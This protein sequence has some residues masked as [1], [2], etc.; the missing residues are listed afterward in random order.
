M[1]TTFNKLHYLKEVMRL[2]LLNKKEDEEIVIADGGSTDGT[3]EFLQDLYKYGKVDQFISEKDKGEAH[4]FN[5]TFLLARGELIKIITDDD[6]YNYIAIA[7][8]KKYMLENP[9]VEVMTGNVISVNITQSPT[10]FEF[11]KSYQVWFQQWVAG[12][13]NSTFFSCLPLML[14]KDCIPLIG[15]FDTSYKHVD[16]EFSVRVTAFKRNVTFY[17]GIV[18]IGLV[19]EKSVSASPEAG[20]SLEIAKKRL[21]GNYQFVDQRDVRHEKVPWFRKIVLKKF[22]LLNKAANKFNLFQTKT[23]FY[24]YI[25][26]KI[27]ED[28]FLPTNS[29]AGIFNY[30]ENSSLLN[31]AVDKN[32]K[33]FIQKC[34]S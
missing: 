1:I 17:T 28:V 25:D 8:M 30:F 12:N 23:E 5:K 22:N 18:A 13:I 16:F 20:R 9:T 19:N 26:E 11:R 3:I 4:G 34:V 21:S 32:D 15:L 24:P 31:L 29:T 27:K 33:I 10:Y 2:L 14:R 6:V 7:E